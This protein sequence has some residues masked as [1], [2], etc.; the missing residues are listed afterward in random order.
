MQRALEKAGAPEELVAWVGEVGAQQAWDTCAIADWVLWLAACGGIPLNEIVEATSAVIEPAAARVN[1]ERAQPLAA[2]LEAMR[3]RDRVV[4]TQAVG[5]L[6]S[7]SDT[8][9]AG[10]RGGPHRGYIHCVRALALL[11]RAHESLVAVMDQ[12]AADAVTEGIA[13]GTAPLPLGRPLLVPD[14]IPEDPTQQVLGFVITAA[15]EAVHEA[16]LAHAEHDDDEAIKQA[17]AELSD[18]LHELLSG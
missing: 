9:A 17:H 13:R 6:E 14:L 8:P 18:R 16:A 5:V 10:Y 15:T 12:V 3:A 4:L 1:G 7:I 11:G 2:A